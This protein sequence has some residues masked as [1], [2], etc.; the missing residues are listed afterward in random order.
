MGRRGADRWGLGRWGMLAV[1]SAALIL[2]MTTWF[3]ATAIGPDLQARFHLSTVEASWLTNAVQLGFVVSA[4]TLSLSGLADAWAIRPLM[5]GAS[6]LAAV[7]NLAIL[8]APDDATLFAARFVTGAA[9][10]GVY[11]PALKLIATWFATGRGLAMGAAL[12]A[13]TLGSSTPYLVR[14]LGGALDWRLV[15]VTA[16]VAA[17]A[18]AA[19]V[20]A[21]VSEGPNAAARPKPEFGRILAVARDPALSLANLGYFGHM[22]ELYA[23][24]S[25]FVAYA[26]AASQVGAL[27]LNPALLAF[28]VIAAGTFGCLLGGVLGDR[29]GRTATAGLMM[30]VSGTCALTIGFAFAGPAWL[31]VAIALLWG[32]AVIADSAQFSAMI[33][34]LSDA[35]TTGAA[36]A[37]QVGVGFALTIVSIRLTPV[38]AAH[39][40]WHWTFA[41]L[42]P[43]PMIGAMAMAALRAM[44]RSTA[45]ANGR[46]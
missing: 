39:I 12:G 44:P 33:S 20:L 3:S 5:A 17:A 40:G 22:W 15:V 1:T 18:A 46:R 4:L 21:F 36:L 35:H 45:I 32:V 11:P 30:L 24:W 27:P 29:I 37:L 7:S 8:V 41:M 13:L 34:E 6:L 16:S 10:A 42:A 25:W 2:S 23:L 19:L 31:F 26:G 14:G 9:L 28:L 38:L 43:G